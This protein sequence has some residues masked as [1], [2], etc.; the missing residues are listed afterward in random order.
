ELD[1]IVPISKPAYSISNLDALKAL[2]RS[3]NLSRLTNN[4]LGKTLLQQPPFVSKQNS[5]SKLI[6]KTDQMLAGLQQLRKKDPLSPHAHL[7]M[8]EKDAEDNSSR[9]IFISSMNHLEDNLRQLESSFTRRTND[10]LTSFNRFTSN[11]NHVKDC[12]DVTVL[13]EMLQSARRISLKSKKVKE[14][15]LNILQLISQRQ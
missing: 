1:N 2:R 3:S 14:N 7:Y 13:D 6:V 12:K 15:F 11:M 4:K 10:I 5:R 9:D 8:L